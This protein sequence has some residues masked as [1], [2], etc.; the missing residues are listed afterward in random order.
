MIILV[1][2]DDVL[3][4]FDLGFLQKWR[5]MY[6]DK[7]YVPLEERTTFYIRENYP[8]E[9]TLLVDSVYSAHGF[10][11]SIPPMPGG[12]EAITEMQNKGHNVFICTS[13][14]SRFEDCVLEKYLWTEEHLG[15]EW[16]KKMILTNDKTLVRGDILIDDRPEIKGACEPAWEHIL[17]THNYNKQITSKRRLTWQNWKEVLNL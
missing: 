11:R 4:D 9:L 10:Y 12:K 1:D 15:R 7:P 5:E 17:Y 13:P 16:T 2:Q 8:K 6:P 14:L 3:A